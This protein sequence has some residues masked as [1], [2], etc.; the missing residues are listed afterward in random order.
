MAFEDDRVA[1]TWRIGRVYGIPIRLHASLALILPVMAIFFARQIEQVARQ[2][3]FV[4]PALVWGAASAVVL[5]ASVLVH[6]IAHSVMAVRLGGHVRGITLLFLGGVSEL[7]DVLVPRRE[8]LVTLV[9]PLA[10]LAIG[11]VLLLGRPLFAGLPIDAQASL[12]LVGALNL[13]LGLFNLVPAFPLDGGRL[14]RA[15]LAMRFGRL[16]ATRIAAFIGKVLALGFA[17]VGVRW[18]DVTLLI[19][20]AFVYVGAQREAEGV[21]LDE[22]TFGLRVLDATSRTALTLPAGTS[23]G[24]AAA[25]LHGAS[26]DS[27]V[28][29]DAFGRPVG[30]VG[31]AALGAS[32]P[33]VPIGYLPGARAGA[34][35]RDAPLGAALAKL[36]AAGTRA[37]PVI[38]ATGILVGVIRRE[39]VER[40][41]VRG[42]TPTVAQREPAA[43]SKDS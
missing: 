30:V 2:A 36:R 8:A 33:G 25:S 21:E 24:A 26:A 43:P 39:D 12:Q 41:L 20:C 40:V 11:G 22:A 23:V 18:G 31:A 1:A 7:D 14:L 17:V 42:V 19:V 6:E 27:A 10:S 34:I 3:S 13:V 15:I 4:L 32:P 38:A 28:V 16:S 9:G 37:L 5:F 29:L 35:Q